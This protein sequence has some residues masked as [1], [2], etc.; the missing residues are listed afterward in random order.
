MTKS[1]VHGVSKTPLMGLTVGEIFDRTA[2]RWPDREA[3]VVRHQKVRW[4]YG[5]LKREVDALA[6]GLL[7]LG[8]EPG[9]RVGIWSPNNAEWVVTQFATAKAGLILVNVNPAYRVSEVE[10]DLVNSRPRGYRTCDG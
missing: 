7:A 4:S 3:L 2:G 1:Y 10:P 5:E 8:L 6:A 9:D